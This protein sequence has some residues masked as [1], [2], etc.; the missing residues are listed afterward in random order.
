MNSA[1]KVISLRQTVA[2]IGVAASLLACV[3]A[4]ADSTIVNPQPG[5]GGR[6]II[7]SPSGGTTVC[8]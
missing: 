7:C 6:P 8:N 1:F 5:G 2:A 3:S 4:S